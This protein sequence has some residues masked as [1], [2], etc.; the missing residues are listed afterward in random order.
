MDLD[1]QDEDMDLGPPGRVSAVLDPE[2]GGRPKK[3]APGN[4]R[5]SAWRLAKLNA[6]EASRAAEKARDKSSVLQK[7]GGGHDPGSN[8]NN[9]NNAPGESHY[10]SSSSRSAVSV[11]YALQRSLAKRAPQKMSSPRGVP[12]LNPELLRTRAVGYTDSDLRSS[13]SSH[14]MT[15]TISES[16][17]PLPA[18]VRYGPSEPPHTIL[19][20]TSTT[21]PRMRWGVHD[22]VQQEPAR[23][24]NVFLRDHRR[25]AVFWNRPGLGRFGGDSSNVRAQSRIL[26]GG[27]GISTSTFP[28][29]VVRTWPKNPLAA[30]EVSEESGTPAPPPPPAPTSQQQPST[31][32]PESFS[33]FF[34]P[35]IVPVGA[36]K[37]TEPPPPPPAPAPAP[38]SKP[39]HLQPRVP[40]FYP[41]SFPPRSESPTFGSDMR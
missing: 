21:I 6:Q 18:E 9:S 31:E 1:W 38:S 34:G 23:E 40:A 17:S 22:T 35:P 26:F 12:S 20:S 33:I 39:V 10:S 11:E 5:I 27:S 3:K 24:R 14:S 8:N 25:S 37:R 7:L 29:Q 13:I 41:R 16:L 15:S 32:K 4:V 2:G 19:P 30:E 28:S 36:G